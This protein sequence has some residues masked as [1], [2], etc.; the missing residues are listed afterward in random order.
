MV[1]YANTISNIK[2]TTNA[3]FSICKPLFIAR[4]NLSKRTVADLTVAVHY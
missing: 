4:I 2:F 1:L 3:T